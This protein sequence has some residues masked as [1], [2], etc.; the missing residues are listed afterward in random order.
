MALFRYVMPD[1]AAPQFVSRWD[2]VLADATDD[3][4]EESEKG[5][6]LSI[7]NAISFSVAPVLPETATSEATMPPVIPEITTDNIT[8]PIVE[9]AAAVSDIII[10]EPVV[11]A[12][13]NVSNLTIPIPTEAHV[14]NQ[15]D[16]PEIDINVYAVSAD[17][18]PT[19]VS[20]KS[21]AVPNQ[22]EGET[23][24]TTLPPIAGVHIGNEVNAVLS[25]SA[26][27]DTNFESLDWSPE[28]LLPLLRSDICLTP[29]GQGLKILLWNWNKL[30]N[31]HKKK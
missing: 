30:F 5:S 12:E 21:L 9:I 24:R 23:N 6:I 17:V 22:N 7:S 20:S 16:V 31:N 11:V 15:L 28:H 29:W 27:K 2:K 19:S 13:Q 4:D 18:I 25:S 3:T 1:V 26:L 8:E 14:N 10:N